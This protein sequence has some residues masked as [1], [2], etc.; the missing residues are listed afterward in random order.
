MP[1]GDSSPAWLHV[2]ICHVSVQMWAGGGGS[3]GTWGS[4]G[5]QCWGG[6][7]FLPRGTGVHL[8]LR[9]RQ[10]AEAN[11]TQWQGFPAPLAQLILPVSQKHP[12]PPLPAL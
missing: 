1:K 9:Q 6:I 11:V 4:L 2:H 12:R 3:P 8:V 10:A 7:P 5:E